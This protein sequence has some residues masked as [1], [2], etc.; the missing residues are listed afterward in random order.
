MNPRMG[1]KMTVK[2]KSYQI[3]ERLLLEKVT[4]T[5]DY[6]PWLSL[7]TEMVSEHFQRRQTITAVSQGS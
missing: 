7:K 3:D 1:W 4:K 5:A 6:W 2:D